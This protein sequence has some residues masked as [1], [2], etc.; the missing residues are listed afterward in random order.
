MD[1]PSGGTMNGQ[2]GIVIVCAVLA[3]GGIIELLMTGRRH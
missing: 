2:I 1:S 3:I